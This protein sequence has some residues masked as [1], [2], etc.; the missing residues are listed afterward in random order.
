MV[1]LAAFFYWLFTS[2]PRVVARYQTNGR[3]E[4]I[5]MAEEQQ[6]QAAQADAKGNDKAATS[7]ETKNTDTESPEITIPKHR[8]DEVSRKLKALEDE[9]AKEVKEREQEDKKKL[10]AQQEWQKLYE[11]SDTKVQELTPKAELADKLSALV[12]EQYQA[13]IKDWP[14]QVRAMAPSEDASILA[15]L[16]WMAKAKPLAV[17][18]LKDKTP[19]AG[20]GRRPVVAGAAKSQAKKEIEPIYDVRRNF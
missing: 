13:E 1:S 2:S 10:A 7:A 18:L 9:R 17:E 6:A 4:Y 8:Y 19:V 3:K 20:N 12:T 15:K 5:D 16:E 11:G 14:E